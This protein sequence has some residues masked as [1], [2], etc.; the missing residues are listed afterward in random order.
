[1]STLD[2]TRSGKAAPWPILREFARLP[3]QKELYARAFTASS[4]PSEKMIRLASSSFN[5]TAPSGQFPLT[6]LALGRGG[7]S[8]ITKRASIT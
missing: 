4:A 8:P 1:M 2:T 6:R 5:V 7:S 3:L